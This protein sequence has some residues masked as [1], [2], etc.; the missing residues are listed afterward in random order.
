M[1]E[2]ATEGTVEVEAVPA[3][4]FETPTEPTVDDLFKQFVSEEEV[5]QTEKDSILPVGT[6]TTIPEFKVTLG[7]KDGRKNARLFGRIFKVDE[8]DVEIKGA[9]GYPLSWQRKNKFE[10]IKDE[11]TG[12]VIDKKDTGKPDYLSKMFAQAVKAYTVA[13]GEA[14]TELDDAGTVNVN[15]GKVITYLRDYP[16]KVRVIQTQ[17][18]E[19]MVVSISAVVEK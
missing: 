11:S 17:N 1:S 16:H 10:E 12:V 7:E 5:K 9:I 2:E 8:H 18:N 6:Y 14:P 15:I 13:F 4:D 3:G 19:N